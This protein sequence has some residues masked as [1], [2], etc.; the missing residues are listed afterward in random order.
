MTNDFIA[1][2]TSVK[3]I[4]RVAISNHVFAK[5]SKIKIK[6]AFNPD[7][8]MMVDQF[9]EDDPNKNNVLMAVK[10]FEKFITEVL[11]Q[12]ILRDE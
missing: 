11:G 8:P 10:G 3:V 7:D 12:K 6:W 2:T 5:G 9:L 4:E 1:K